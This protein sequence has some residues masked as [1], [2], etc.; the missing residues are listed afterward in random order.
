MLEVGY[1]ARAGVP[2]F[3]SHTYVAGL[4]LRVDGELIGES[5]GR[6][7]VARLPLLGIVRN[8]AHERTLG[9]LGEAPFL[10][11]QR[12]RA[13]AEVEP[14]FADE[15]SR[16]PSPASPATSFATWRFP[17]CRLSTLR[18]RRACRR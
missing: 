1:H 18:S 11:G 4:R 14:V 3:V 7:W 16:R 9:S 13:S 5:H 2:A 12:T 10:A 15:R 17:R 6:A 8:N